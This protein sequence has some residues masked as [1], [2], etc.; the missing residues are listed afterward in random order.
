[1]MLKEIIIKVDN[2]DI[3]LSPKLTVPIQQT[4]IPIEHCKFR[5]HE[6]IYWKVE[7]LDYNTHTKCWKMKVI[8]YFTNDLKNFDRQKS[9]KEVDRIAFEKFDWLKFEQHLTNYQ[10]IKLLEVLHNHDADRFFRAEP[11]VNGITALPVADFSNQAIEHS[12]PQTQHNLTSF[13]QTE[14]PPII[15]I[16]RVEFRVSFSDAYFMLGYVNFSR[17]IKE[18]GQK[19]DFKIKNDYILAEFDNIK[20]WFAKKLKTKKFKI[21]ATI[22]TT[23]G[24]VTEVTATSPQIAMIDEELIDSIRYQRTMTLTK[25]PRVSETDKSLFTAEEIFGEM[26]TDDIEGNVFSQNEQDILRF[27]LDNNKTRNRKQLEYLS[28]YKQAESSKLRFTLHPNFGFL[29]FIEG[30][31]NN[32]FVWELLNTHATYIWSIDKSERTIELQYKRIE[33]SINTIRDIG[34]EQYKRAYRQNHQDKDLVFCVIEHDDITSNFVDGFV[35]WKHKL[36]EKIT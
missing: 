32:H 25:S 4:N 36:N 35:K 10:K 33:A 28:G 34:R 13:V 21:N 17:N 5:S 31:E 8:D 24:K 9:T 2:Q 7:L 12:L 11:T 27:L 3:H 20:S 26:E 23:D 19:V 29:F 16:R 18:V 14:R 22:I 6:D 30:K 1:M 15:E